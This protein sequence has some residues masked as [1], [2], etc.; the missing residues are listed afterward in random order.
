MANGPGAGARGDY[1]RRAGRDFAWLWAF[2][3]SPAMRPRFTR[4]RVSACW[5]TLVA[6]RQAPHVER[7]EDRVG[8]GPALE[9]RPHALGDQ[10]GSGW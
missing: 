7:P 2:V 6:L 9:E 5:L 4:R 1:G 3:C 8:F 10:P